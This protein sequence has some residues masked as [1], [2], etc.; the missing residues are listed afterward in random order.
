M[1]AYYD[2][3]RM[4]LSVELDNLSKV[5]G[6]ARSEYLSETQALVSELRATH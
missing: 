6:D 3:E 4:K 1:R 5:R 2:G